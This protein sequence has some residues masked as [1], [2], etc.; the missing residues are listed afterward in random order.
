MKRLVPERKNYRLVLFIN[1]AAVE[2]HKED[3][4]YFTSA[5][6]IS[7]FTG[8]IVRCSFRVVPLLR[9]E[10]PFSETPKVKGSVV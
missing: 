3:S 6:R 8:G 9:P 5:R 10:S 4:C 1:G 2:Q 7:D